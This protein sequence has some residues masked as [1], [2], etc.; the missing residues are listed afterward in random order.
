MEALAVLP[1]FGTDN[2]TNLYKEHANVHNEDV[3]Q[4]V[5]LLLSET[6]LSAE[7]YKPWEAMLMAI[8]S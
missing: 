7:P 4:A 2:V 1:C 8:V 5:N 6:K 3:A